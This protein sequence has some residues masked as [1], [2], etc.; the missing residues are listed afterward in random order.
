MRLL[1]IFLLLISSLGAKSGL[2]DIEWS[3]IEQTQQKPSTPYPHQ[4]TDGIKDTHLPVYLPSN[5]AYDTK[6][7]VVADKD[8]Y[9]ISFF[10]DNA[11]V[12]MA[13]DRTFQES[14]SPSDSKF[15]K[16]IESP[17]LDFIEDS[18]IMSV[19][20]NRNGANYTLSVECENY[21]KDSRCQEED[22][23]RGLY[24]RLIFIGGKK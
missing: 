5:Y 23:L 14:I 3:K 12:M 8:F 4:L 7:A 6:M 11:T 24:N 16:I 17:P 10:I 15:E 20:F 18:G 22:F 2:L 13:G 19:D 1:P 9:T 21:Q